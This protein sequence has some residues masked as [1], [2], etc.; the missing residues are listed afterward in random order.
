LSKFRRPEYL[1]PTEHHEPKNRIRCPVHGFIHYS[2]N[3]R[4]II[5]HALFRRLRYIRQLALAE[6]VYPGAVHTRFEHSLGAMEVATQAFDSL[7]AKQGAILEEVFGKVVDFEDKPMAKARQVLRL[8]ALL[9]DIGHASFSHAAEKAIFKDLGHEQLSVSIISEDR[10]LK[11]VLDDHFW[12]G[13]HKWVAQII[14][15][16]HDLPVQLTILKNLVSGDMDADRTDYLLRDSHHCGVD[17]GRFDYKRMIECLDLHVDHLGKLTIALQRDGIHTFEAL[18]LARYQMNTQVYYHRLRR[19]YDLYLNNYH[20]SLDDELPDTP[21]KILAQNDITMLSQIFLDAEKASGK[22]KEWA[23]RIK[24]RDHH[25]K[26]FETGVNVDDIGLDHF[27]TLLT[28]VQNQFA[29]IQ[30]LQDTCEVSIHKI[31]VPGDR[32]AKGANKLFLKI[33]QAEIR[34][35]SEQSQIIST[36]P[37]EFA[38]ARIFADLKTHPDSLR[39]EIE[40]FAHTKWRTL[41]GN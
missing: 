40:H 14:V 18:I 11:R 29:D 5:D 15:G 32:K 21:E 24:E 16:D 8:A 28:A 2:N 34:Q 26:I 22:R 39:K 13:C 25:R 6:F 1:D 12:P 35:L 10:F 33:S 30:M 27:K 19:I 4:K 37:K 36:I 9:H 3:E 7:A 31:L 41:G 20:L 17:Y 38:Q 23:R